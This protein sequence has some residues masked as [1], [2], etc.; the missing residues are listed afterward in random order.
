MPPNVIKSFAS[1]VSSDGSHLLVKLGCSLEDVWGEEL[2]SERVG[3][4]VGVL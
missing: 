3:D 4:E 2:S 1:R